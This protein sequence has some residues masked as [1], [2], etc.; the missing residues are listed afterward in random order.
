VSNIVFKMIPFRLG[1][2]Q[3][4]SEMVAIAIGLPPG[5]GLQ[6]SL[7]RTGRVIIWAIVGLA[8]GAATTATAKR[9]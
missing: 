2:D 4:G 6:V 8:T 7:V 1:V 3:V 5:I 9:P